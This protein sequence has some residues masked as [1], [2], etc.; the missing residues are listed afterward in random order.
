M[1]LVATDLQRIR[2]LYYQGRYRQALA[3]GEPYGPLRT[4]TGPASRLMAGRLALQLGA[5]RMGHQLHLVAFRESPAYPE[6]IYYHARYRLETFGPLSCW[7]F[8]RQHPDWSDAQ[9]DLRADWLAVHALAAARLRDFDRADRYLNQADGIAVDRAWLHVERSS[10]LELCE[11]PDEALASARRALEITP[12]FRPGVQAVAHLHQ[13]AGRDREA[14]ELLTQA[15][16]HLESGVIL[17]HLATLQYD[18]R[19]YH[20]ARRSLDQYADLSPLMDREVTKWLAARRADVAYLLNEPTIAVQQAKLVGEDFY[21]QFAERLEAN[22]TADAPQPT[23]ARIVLPVNLSCGDTPLTATEILGRFLNRPIPTVPVDATVA[24]DGIPD[25][26]E[27]RRFDEAGWATRE[28]SL[29][30]DTAGELIA[31]GLPFLVTLVESGFGQSRLILGVDRTRNSVFMPEGLEQRPI[32]API[33]VLLERYQAFGPRCLVVVPKEEAAKL[34]GL[35]LPDS[36]TYNRLHAI[37]C[38]LNDLKFAEAKSLIVA[39]RQEFPGHRLTKYAAIAWARATAHPVLLLDALTDLLVD[40]PHNATLVL[41]KAAVFRDLGRIPERRAI[42]EAEGDQTSAEPL[43]MQSLAQMM[44]PEPKSQDDATRLLRRSIRVRPHAAAGYYLLATQLWEHQQFDEAADY[45]RFATCLDDR[46]EQFAEAYSRALRTLNQ[47]PDA[48]RLFQQRANRGPLPFAPA[49]RS[50]FH[51]LHDREDVDFAFAAIGK[52]IEKARQ[53]NGNSPGTE[54]TSVLAELLLFRAEMLA[55]AGKHADAESDLA[56]AQPHAVPAMW[57]RNAARLARIKPDYRAAVESMRDLLTHEPLVADNHRLLAGLIADT[58]GRDVATRYFAELAHRYPDHYGVAKLAAEFVYANPDTG[59]IRVTNQLLELCPHD[60]W[61]HRQ[62]AMLYAD[63]KD[64]HAAL[65]AIQKAAESEPTH[66]SHYAVLAHVHRRADRV[67]E[68]L[69]AFRDG[70]KRFPDHELAIYEMVQVSRGLKEKKATLRFIAEQLHATPHTGDGLLAYF[71]QASELIDE[72]EEF[73][74]FLDE[75]ERFLDERPD[76]W[77]AWSI[78]IQTMT[79]AQRVDEALSLAREAT[80]RFPLVPRVWIDLAILCRIMEQPDERL[81]ALKRAVAVAPGW[82]PAVRELADALSEAEQYAEA[83]AVLERLVPRAAIDPLAHWAFAERLWQA[84]RG[85]EAIQRAMQAVRLDT[86]ADPRIETAWSAVLSWTERIDEPEEAIALARSLTKDRAGD[87]RAWLRFARCITDASKA[88]EIL[89]ALDTAIR[90]DPRNIEAHDLKAERLAALGRFDDALAAARPAA[91]LADLPLVLQGRAAWIEARRGNYAAA[92]PPMQALVAV[93]PDYIWGWQQLAEWYNDTGR[94]ESYLEAASELLRLR[95]DHPMSLTMR[96]EAKLQTGDREGGKEDLR[97]ALRVHPGYSPAAVILFDACLSDAEY[98]DAR[99]ALA[100]LQEHL[101]GP[102][103]LVKQIQYASRTNDQDGAARAFGELC[104]TP[105]DGPAMFMQMGLNEM[106]SLDQGEKAAELLFEA[107]QSDEEFSPWAGIFWLDTPDGDSADDE[108]KLEAC[109]VTVKQYPHFVPA[110]DRRAEQLAMMGLYEEAAAACRPDGVTPLPIAL[111]GRAAW[112]E[113]HRGDRNAAISIMK[114]ILV[115]EPDYSWGWRQLTH[116]Y[117][118]LGR[119]RDCL[120]AADQLVRLN[121]VDPVAHAIRGEAKRMLGDN[122]GAKEDFQKAFEIDPAFQ[123]AGLQLISSQLDTND[124]IGAAR[125]LAVL[126]E[127]SDGPL[128][129]LRALQVS[130][131]QGNLDQARKI[132]R[133][134]LADLSVNRSILQEA[135]TDFRTAGWQAEADD[136]LDAAT[137]TDNMTPAAAGVWA[138]ALMLSNQPWKVADNLSGLIDR[139]RD[140]G[141]EAVLIY[142]MAMAVVGRTD[143]AVTTIQRFAEVLRQEDNSWARAGAALVEAKQYEHAAAWL[144]DWYDRPDRENW[145]LRPLF[146]SYQ[147]MGEDE[148]AE[149]IAQDAIGIDEDEDEYAADFL[150]WLALFAAVKGDTEGAEEYLDRVEP[151]GQP[152]GVKLVIKMAEVLIDVQ[153]ADDKSRAFSEAKKDLQA[154]ADACAS[155]DLLPGTPRWYQRAAARLAHDANTM[156]AK[157]WAWW[158][159]VKPWVKGG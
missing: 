51:T 69:E 155:K 8:L 92:I 12:W 7:H 93:D 128:V 78:V 133:E 86:G 124:L 59:P 127:H 140:A 98:R 44:L 14:I 33:T 75:L 39:M 105:G 150:A 111:Q 5:P 89:G 76:L 130:A 40:F 107:W 83:V 18:Q 61:A 71:N 97:E 55:N 68:A 9:P 134:L 42:L 152:D 4:W 63:R 85:Q 116:W 21:T 87:P 101:S 112:V 35:S 6:A 10:V 99:S 46:E 132:F 125:S 84:D 81:D 157:L 109:D 126:Q 106:H 118:A 145:M 129:K 148:K 36:D 47:S 123:A 52:A 114:K 73:E 60:A 90:L 41:A 139:N 23:A 49:V 88:N 74:R 117:D 154:A 79:N 100:V 70:L 38:A 80:E 65:H 24:M 2:D 110:H 159:R 91:L 77:Q 121:P 137:R 151:I 22:S 131:R 25:A 34:D 95:P 122:R 29:T 58:E 108:L 62:L 15:A 102:E 113:A 119:N 146:D 143:P 32:E 136:E 82:V 11:R 48:L 17:A 37:Q 53:V 16:D 28:F 142:A 104:T 30:I 72:P 56:A 31:R 67:D 43:L 13:R 135:I 3:V 64:H 141:R 19:R 138:D 120:D 103:V 27:R 147:A 94:S 54:S 115:E 149:L 96:G 26:A 1:E 20:D 45:Y 156:N 158:Q 57:F 153:R 66:P 50:L 144:S